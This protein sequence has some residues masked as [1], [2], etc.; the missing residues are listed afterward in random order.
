MIPSLINNSAYD[1]LV[2]ALCN[3][4]IHSLWQGILLAA[5][6]GLIVICTRKAS[7]ALRYNLLISAL[8]LFAIAVSAT[9][10]WQYQKSGGVAAAQNFV[11]PIHEGN[12]VIITN[13]DAHVAPAP[14]IRFTDRVN[15]YLNDHHNTIVL[16]WFLI[17]CARSMQ[18]GV[19]LYG[20]YRLKTTRV[21]RLK[22]HWPEHMQQLADALGIKQTFTLL[23]SGLAKVPM[24]IGHL[25]PVVL[26]PIGLLTA[27]SAE[28]VEAILV[29]ELAHIKRRD[30]LV[31]MLQ[32]LMEIVLFFNPAVLWV[33]KLIKTERENCCD[34]LALAQNNNRINYIRALVSCEE[35]KS[36]VPAY[37]MAFPGG[38]LTLLDRVKRIAGNRNHS[39]NM[40]EK[41]VLAIC[42]VALGLGVSAFTARESIKKALKSVAAAIHHN[43]GVEHKEKAKLIKNDTTLKRQAT[44]VNDVA[45]LLNKVQQASALTDTSKNNGRGP[46][47]LLSNKLDS[48]SGNGDDLKWRPFIVNKMDSNLLKNSGA[49]LKWRSWL[50]KKMDTSFRTRNKGVYKAFHD[51]GQELYREHLLTDTNHMNISLNEH[52]LIVNGVRM[53]K[54]VHDRIYKQ[55]GAKGSS[56]TYNSN[57]SDG[58]PGYYASRDREDREKSQQ[59]GAELLR[60]DNLVKDKSHFTYKLNKDGLYIDG[61]KQPDELYRR[62]VDEY[63]KRD[64]NFNIGY[65]FKDP[66]TYGE[67]SSRYNKS[68]ADYQR[69][70]EEQQRYWAGQRRKII[71]EMAREGLINDRNVVSFTLT[72]KT[73]V[74]NGLVQNNEVFQRYHQEYVPVHTGDNWNWNYNNNPGNPTE[75]YRSRDWEAYSRQTAAERQRVEAER[76]KKLVVDLMQDGLITGPNNVTF[77]L[78]DKKL[79]INGKK[80]SEELYNKY[81]DKYVPNNTGSDWS[82]TYSHHE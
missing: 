11:Q 26:I 41:T 5:V 39:L 54:E 7:S 75:A 17:I 73:F 35:Y 82:W 27:L 12:I 20:T 38:K 57:Y 66:G 62:I 46:F 49:D 6:A 48:M 25:K 3:T 77:T 18:L 19:G 33:S 24:V 8:L 55:Y 76:D 50:L 58:A 10:V 34:D 80:Q 40:F 15:N 36:S 37:A 4:L 14:H 78:S 2:G 59:I 64:D 21:F 69:Q 51:I 47:S 45:S 81:K 31:N 56:G 79:E 65:T 61:E 28:E 44:P 9:F 42:L 16:I 1:R 70:S 72:D 52:E 22:G 30:Y 43:V 13:L 71:D 68:S 23:E 32:S 60:E 53:P 63:F 67:S 74:I 29:H